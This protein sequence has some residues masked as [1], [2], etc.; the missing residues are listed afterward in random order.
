MEILLTIL[1][2]YILFGSACFIIIFSSVM[3]K[4]RMFSKKYLCENIKS[5]KMNLAYDNNGKI[6]TAEITIAEKHIHIDTKTG[7]KY[8]ISIDSIIH[9]LF[10]E[11]LYATIIASLIWPAF[12]VLFSWDMLDLIFSKKNKSEKN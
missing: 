9:N 10:M 11:D 2:W 3:I 4:T 12:A 5:G 1:S 8:D 7:V 6:D